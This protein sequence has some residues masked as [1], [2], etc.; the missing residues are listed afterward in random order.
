[1]HPKGSGIKPAARQEEAQGR[2]SLCWTQVGK[3]R[4]RTRYRNSVQVPSSA[5]PGL[6]A[7]QVGQL[8][9]VRTL[10]PC[11]FG[12]MK[13]ISPFI[14][15]QVLEDCCYATS[16]Y[17]HA[18][19]CRPSRSGRCAVACCILHRGSTKF[20]R[21]S[22]SRAAADAYLYHQPRARGHSSSRRVNHS[23]R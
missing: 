5:A 20:L 12:P 14:E 1:M 11:A 8:P 23:H 15:T 22:Q 17:V 19:H 3:R 4:S 21:V 18:T 6:G 10:A 7:A 2:D 9:G 16:Q 13:V